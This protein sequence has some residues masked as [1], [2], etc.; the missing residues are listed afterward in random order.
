MGNDVLRNCVLV[1]I[2]ALRDDR[3]IEEV[4]PF[5]HRLAREGARFPTSY[6][7]INATDPSFTS[8]YTGKYPI[9]HGIV[10]HGNRV[11]EKEIRRVSA[12]PFMQEILAERGFST[13][14]I[15]FL[16]RWHRRGFSDYVTPKPAG[17]RL[18]LRLVG[19]LPSPV[20]SAIKKVFKKAR[21]RK[22]SL[23]YTAAMAGDVAENLM[24][25]YSSAGTRFFIMVHLWDTHTP[26]P[27]VSE[28]AEPVKGPRHSCGT[29]AQ[30]TAG[31]KG[32]W[33]EK[34]LEMFGGETHPSRVVARYE[35]GARDA[36]SLVRRLVSVAEELGIL[37]DTLLIITSDHGESLGEHG[38]WFDHHGLY[39]VTARTPL[40]FY[41]PS[42]PAK[43]VT[44]TAQNIDIMPTTLS[45][46]GVRG[47]PKDIDGADLSPYIT[48]TEEPP[49]DLINRPIFLEEAHT[50]R[51]FALVHNGYKY[52][53]ALNKEAATCRYCG[54]VHG[55][56]EEL[57]D[58]RKD[59]GEMNDIVD[60]N[61]DIAEEMRK[62]IMK[63]L[64]T[65][66]LRTA[67]LRA[68]EAVLKSLRKGKQPG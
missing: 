36:D 24:R 60:S 56:L 12:H 67:V 57:Y 8:I 35:Q 52:I 59:P 29:L 4:M 44:A 23:P 32:P 28:G 27:Q 39:E 21:G 66:G 17:K 16:G 2:D 7:T 1:I 47:V 63:H 41:S 62:A 34:L 49:E 22:Y 38:I 65:A 53:M 14:A 68:R 45:L 11:T 9:H 40:I 6:T 15:D 50:E 64:R 30:C 51:K 25:A 20:R 55:G 13:A 61:R 19:K 3:V 33:R 5:T 58:L 31:I 37:E 10:N 43:E 48:G 26:Y 42:I 46:L 54:I 18:A